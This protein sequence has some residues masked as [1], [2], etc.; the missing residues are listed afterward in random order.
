MKGCQQDGR[1]P[2]PC[3]WFTAMTACDMA[4]PLSTNWDTQGLDREQE[5]LEGGDHP[6]ACSGSAGDSSGNRLPGALAPCPPPKCPLQSG[7]RCWDG[8]ST[9][10]SH[11]PQL[12]LAPQ[13]VTSPCPCLEQIRSSPGA[14]LPLDQL[15]T[16]GAVD[17]SVLLPPRDNT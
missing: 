9:P 6:L 11:C 13:A 16:V 10:H 2:T 7:S 5:C 17:K 14:P 12:S 4:S 1:Q 15:W 8:G 3:C